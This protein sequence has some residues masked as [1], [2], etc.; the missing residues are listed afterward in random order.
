MVKRISFQPEDVDVC[1]GRPIS[2]TICLLV[3]SLFL[4][5]PVASQTVTS[6]GLGTAVNVNGNT[7]EITGGTKSGANLFHSFGKFGLDTGFS[8]DFQNSVGG[9]ISNLIGRVTGGDVS[10]I[11]GQ[12]RSSITGANLFLINPAGFVFGPN[13][14][15][16]VSGSFH[17]STANNIK[18]PDGNVFSATTPNGSTFSVQSPESFGFLTGGATPASI[19]I[20][21]TLEVPVGKTL[22]LV[23]GD[24]NIER[25]AIIAPSGIVNVA[26][27]AS[28]ATVTFN[29]LQPNP[30]LEIAGASDLGSISITDGLLSTDGDPGGTILVRGGKLT[31]MRVQ[32]EAG[33]TQITSDTT[34]ASDGP[35]K[36]VKLDLTQSLFTQNGIISSSVFGAG[37]GGDIEIVANNV[38]LFNSSIVSTVVSGATGN[39]GDIKISTTGNSVNVVDTVINAA[40]FGSGNGGDVFVDTTTLDIK[41]NFGSRIA[42]L[43]NGLG[44]A[45]DLTI[46]ADKVNV[47]AGGTGFF[48]LTTQVSSVFNT[49]QTTASA[50]TLTLNVGEL[51]VL[52]GAQ[53]S[54]DLFIGSGQPGTIN[55]NADKISVSGNL[56]TGRIGGIFATAQGGFNTNADSGSINIT[57]NTISLND[58]GNISTFHGAIGNAGPISID[59][60]ILSVTNGSTINATH[61]GLGNAGSVTITAD[62]I[63][64]VGPAT[65]GRFT[66]IFSLGGVS[67]TGAGPITI[68]A[69]TIN[70]TDG[71][72]ISARTNGGGTGGGTINV[73]AG[74]L[75][76]SG[77]DAVNNIPSQI[78]AATEIFG[79]FGSFAT[80]AAGSINLDA[81]NLSVEDRAQ[82]TVASR[83]FGNAG[84]ANI[85]AGTLAVTGGAAITS[86]TTMTGLGGDLN[87]NV[88]GTATIDGVDANGNA[89]ALSSQSGGS[90]AGGNVNLT[91][92]DVNVSQGGTIS[93]DG[94]GTGRSGDITVSATNDLTLDNG[95]IT[96]SAA[97]ADGGNIVIKVTNIVQI[98]NSE[99]TTSVGSGSGSGGNIDIDPVFVIL[100]NS[101]VQ[102]NAFGGAGGNITIV[103][104]Q[105]LASPDSVIEASSEFGV[106][107]SISV[108]SPDT[109]V[110]GALA[111]LP[112]SLADAASQ[113]AQQCSARGGR[114]M[115]SFVGTGRG[116]L[117]VG[118]GE[119]IPAFYMAA[120]QMG[121]RI[122]SASVTPAL[123][124]FSPGP[125]S[126]LTGVMRSQDEGK[127][128]SRIAQSAQ[129]SPGT[130]VLNCVS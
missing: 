104:D 7:Y 122:R 118:V 99:I 121:E 79:P 12:I 31:L 108:T 13:A 106:S 60:G 50:G 20:N 57:A 48:G 25:G 101:T 86:A 37:D 126:A 41:G 71:A 38:D 30:T 1:R 6:S 124:A 117:P 56:S 47:L 43:S 58:L 39:S 113:L 85:N 35:P 21:G 112:A 46:N 22:S 42:T 51:Q 90:G 80:G 119:P 94:T 107:G 97:L 74:S 52:N 72:Q 120:S 65:P 2:A 123:N 63:D 36:A 67:T 115:A 77:V 54:A 23:G 10:S 8:A 76:V 32:G 105:F 110:S 16:D 53:V 128:K 89:S 28:D 95:I 111:V 5:T 40:V 69:E 59:T 83:S 68:D 61:F 93:A 130:M 81:G 92:L 15:L 116:G 18:F 82:I 125:H 64:L 29:S 127:A 55:I 98:N 19:G 70:L 129:L 4:V 78:N 66:G 102:A 73:T 49:P 114:T 91:A 27:V 75:T 11:D 88:T 44:D 3:L 17:A 45:G 109:D 9:Q 100:R 96:T 24:I 14:S 26:S 84:T 87:I 62:L 103:A 34:G 33:S